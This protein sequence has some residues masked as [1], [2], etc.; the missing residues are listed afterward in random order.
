V[1]PIKAA[2][3]F[4]VLIDGLNIHHGLGPDE[5]TAEDMIEAVDEQLDR[6]FA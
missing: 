1:V 5:L 3:R 6:F 4:I 2:R